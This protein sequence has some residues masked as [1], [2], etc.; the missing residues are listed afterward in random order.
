MVSGYDHARLLPFG[1]TFGGHFESDGRLQGDE[2][3]QTVDC[4]SSTNTCS[5]KVPAPGFAL[6]FLTDDAFSDSA[7]GGSP[8]TFSTSA[9]TKTVNTATVD[10]E[11]LATSNGRRHR[12]HI[13]GST[14][15]G[16]MNGAIGVSQALPRVAIL[17]AMIVG[18][19]IV[20]RAIV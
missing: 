16:S 18:A 12:K 3:I 1:Q 6:V 7:G 5:I 19:L 15:K 8:T 4:D 9:F 14:S 2:D 10:S 13:L 20:G 17:G 11:V